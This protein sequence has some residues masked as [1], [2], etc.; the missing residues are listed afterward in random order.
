M[1]YNSVSHHRQSL[2]KKGYYYAQNGVY[3]ITV[4]T[5]NRHCFLAEFNTPTLLT[6]YGIIVHDA[7]NNTPIIRPDV[8]LDA[9][10][11]MPNHIHG[12]IVICGGMSHGEKSQAGVSQYAPTGFRSPSQTIGAIIRGFKSSTTKQINQMRGTPDLPVWQRN[13]YEHIIRN[14]E[15]LNRIREY[16][17]TNPQHWINDI[18]FIRESES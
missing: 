7:W 14:E 3:F 15:E 16:I 12:F 2:R 17:S 6:R 5:H 11:I 4:C 18:H 9:F 10:V 8:L 1:K 13:Y